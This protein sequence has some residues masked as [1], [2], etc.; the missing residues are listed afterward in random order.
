MIE[1]DVI[2]IGA[3]MHGLA[4]AARLRESR[5]DSLTDREH[6]LSTF[7]R[8][9]IPEKMLVL[10]PSGEWLQGWNSRLDFL[11][12]EY[13]RS[14]I[15]DHPDPLDVHSLLSFHENESPNDYRSL[16]QCFD[17]LQKSKSSKQK[18][19]NERSRLLYKAPKTEVFR[20]FCQELIKR[21]DLGNLV[22]KE[23]VI[24]ISSQQDL[25]DENVNED[26]DPLLCVRCDSGDCFFGK[27]VICAIG[28]CNQP[29][30]PNWCIE[31]LQ[32]LPKRFLSTLCHLEH[33]VCNE[34]NCV[35]HAFDSTKRL[36]IVGGGLS[37]AQMAI[38]AASHGAKDVVMIVRNQIRSR[39]LDS[40]SDLTLS[41]YRNR[42]HCNFLAL[43]TTQRLNY[44][45]EH[46]A[47]STIPPDVYKDLRNLVHTGILKILEHTEVSKLV[48]IDSSTNEI[49]DLSLL[50]QVDFE[51]DIHWQVHLNENNTS[52]V[53]EFSRILLATGYCVD[54]RKE[55]PFQSLLS[56]NKMC[57]EGG[58]PILSPD[59]RCYHKIPLYILGKYASE[60]LGLMA[61][62]IAGA[63]KGSRLVAD[64]IRDQLCKDIID[65]QPSH[66]N[67]RFGVFL[68]SEEDED[69]FL[70]FWSA[71]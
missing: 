13:L 52:S 41:R 35:L 55:I 20:M 45:K 28:A 33:A 23:K 61:G 24:S 71:E 1:Y 21:Y 30:I 8:S 10:D 5:S 16:S 32:R 57:H 26:N 48:C 19:V 49:L 14:P 51:K 65:E 39:W 53:Q 9:I 38:R 4:T 58:Y 12:V 64:S 60:E 3:G 66:L 37:A 11:G 68:D 70:E 7:S 63:I 34:K 36:L 22:R 6:D 31:Y 50:E 40:S 67:N 18:M 2:I 56:N 29:V 43:S 59:L 17:S 44:L 46:S 69:E 47:Q 62:N 25:T 15:T 27:N 42:H 54:V